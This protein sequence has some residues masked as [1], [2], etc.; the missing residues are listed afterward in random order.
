MILLCLLSASSQGAACSESGDIRSEAVCNSG[1]PLVRYSFPSLSLSLSLSQAE[2]S[3]VSRGHSK[4]GELLEKAA[5]H[6]MS[7]FRVCVSDM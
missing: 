6:I 4:P 3:R 5:D 1:M 7:C 2:T